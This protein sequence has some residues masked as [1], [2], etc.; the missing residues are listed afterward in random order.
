MMRKIKRVLSLIIMFALTLSFAF[1]GRIAGTT[2]VKASTVLSGSTLTIKGFVNKGTLGDIIT[3]P[4]GA[5]N[6]TVEIK[7]PDRKKVTEFEENTTEH[8]KLVAK[9]LGYYTVQYFVDGDFTRSQI[10]TIKIEGN[11]PTIEFEEN[12]KIY[13]PD[14]IS[15]GTK[16][17]LPS[18]IVTKANGE[19]L[20][21]SLKKRDD[22]SA[23][24]NDVIVSV[25]APIL[26]ES[27]GDYVYVSLSYDANGNV[28]FEPYKDADNKIVYGS[29][30]VCYTYQDGNMTA[31]KYATIKVEENFEE[32]INNIKMTFDWKNNGS[33]PTSGNLGSEIELPI[34]VAKDKSR[35]NE[36]LQS[37][38]QVKVQFIDQN[39]NAKD[40]TFDYANFSFVPMDSTA[41]GGY[42]KI[43]YTITNYFGVD[44]IT[45][46]Y[47]IRNVTDKVSPDIYIVNE[48]TQEQIQ[49]KT[50]D[51]TDVSYKIPNKIVVSYN[52]QLVIP[53]LYAIDNFENYE[54][55]TLRRYWKTEDRTITLDSETYP[56]NK[57][58]V[59]TDESMDEYVKNCL[60]TPGT[61]TIRYEARDK[62]NSSKYIDF[63]IVVLERNNDAIDA[64]A[65]E[66]DNLSL[67]KTTYSGQKVTFKVP[68]VADYMMVDGQKV[69]GT[70]R[71][72]V[73]A[74]YYIGDNYASF[75]EAFKK[76]ESIQSY[77]DS[78]EFK[79]ISKDKDNSNYYSF[80]VPTLSVN[81]T[82]YVVVRATDNA[83]YGMANDGIAKNNISVK[84]GKIRL[85]NIDASS[86][87]PPSLVSSVKSTVREFGQKELIDIC[88]LS[89]TGKFT[90]AGDNADFTKLSVNIYDPNGK[91]V[92]VKGL[93]TSTNSAKTQVTLKKAT[94]TSTKNGEYIV[95]I[96]ATD[97]ANNSTIV[98]YKITVND[99]IAPVI[100]ERD[101]VPTTMVVGKT[102]ELPSIIVFDNGEEIENL[103]EEE[104]SFEGFNDNLKY[105]FTSGDNMFTPH[106]IGTYTFKYIAS[107]GVNTVELIK[108][109][110]VVADTS[111]EGKLY[112]DDSNWNPSYPLIAEKVDGVETGAYKTI[113]LPR[114]QDKNAKGPIESY[115]V[116]VVGP[117]GKE[118]SVTEV[119]GG[120]KFEPSAKD[121]V[122]TV[123][124]TVRDSAGQ[125]VTLEKTIKVGDTVNPKL[126]INN[127]KVNLPTS[128]KLDSTLTIS[129]EDIVYSDDISKKSDITVVVSI[130]DT[131]GNVTTLSRDSSSNTYTYKFEKAG[132][133]TLTY[134]VTDKAGNSA[135]KSTEIV[136]NAQS[137]TEKS[138][139]TVW[140][141]ALI[142][143][144]VAFLL[145]VVV[146]FVVTNKKAKP[147]KEKAK[148]NAKI[149]E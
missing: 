30:T 8:I 61:Y 143:I 57:N 72:L 78:G 116:T 118:M 111:T 104:I 149:I 7:D 26:D 109:I 79:F 145:G 31:T 18:P 23:T 94:F 113:T 59:L 6:I 96:T 106:E 25:K 34:P 11:S 124:Y 53:A 142:A 16:V 128:A 64:L 101:E 134:T 120:F 77:I 83:Q 50:V 24:S 10:Y 141:I 41:N 91:E 132:S 82:I 17:I 28:V 67:T 133:Y 45:R 37:Y 12:A 33:M 60:K 123:T 55:L 42:Y 1:G 36:Q 32:V 48:Y 20:T 107:D 90:F 121:G 137:A 15:S 46:T 110:E 13:I 92:T 97:I 51:L 126:T 108:T 56:V 87:T 40:Y 58:L 9:K 62:S 54:N 84:E 21:Y 130:K 138:V 70:E 114:L 52:G 43:E 81:A 140:G 105:D 44:T 66:I 73:E 139:T 86:I 19:K 71:C 95:V 39:G 76:G 75:I 147:S 103:A 69:T 117:N 146:Y 102:I 98:A 122:Y 74:G 125:T 80:E 65:P 115:K 47:E 93:A 27:L 5:D 68:S 49:N 127:E 4:K 129:A 22:A 119:D 131:N 135:S 100:N 35:A 148:Q 38:T 3:V 85:I 99:T 89:E 112:L 136:V 144:S 63:E 88:E 2:T 14:T 29:Y